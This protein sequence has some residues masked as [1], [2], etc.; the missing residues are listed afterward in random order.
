MRK[1][2]TD[3][4]TDSHKP[5][6]PPPPPPKRGAAAKLAEELAIAREAVELATVAAPLSGRGCETWEDA[7]DRA[8][9]LLDACRERIRQ[10]E[11]ERR[12]AAA[13]EPAPKRT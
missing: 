1:Q 3:P 7:V 8:E 11:A 5:E 9:E 6:P 12:Q 4:P 10:R 2:P 13:A